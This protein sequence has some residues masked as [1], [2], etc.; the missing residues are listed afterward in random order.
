MVPQR[1]ASVPAY[2]VAFSSRREPFRSAG[3]GRLGASIPNTDSAGRAYWVG[4]PGESLPLDP[5][6]ADEVARRTSAAPDVGNRDHQRSGGVESR[7]SASGPRPVLDGDASREMARRTTLRVRADS[8]EEAPRRSPEWPG[9]AAV[10]RGPIHH[11][12]AGT[13]HE[14]L[15]TSARHWPMTH[16]RDRGAVESANSARH[17]GECS[18]P[19]HHH[20]SGAG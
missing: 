7:H 20:S 11:Q 15:A 2:P 1:L 14:L 6:E 4:K 8:T 18:L 12:R 19:A 10:A 9:I 17:G 3:F 16:G 5:V 13:W